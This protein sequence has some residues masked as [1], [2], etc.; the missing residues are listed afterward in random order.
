MFSSAINGEVSA[1]PGK[2]V[3]AGGQWRGAA[4]KPKHLLRHIRFGIKPR[5]QPSALSMK[6]ELMLVILP[7]SA[8]S[9]SSMVLQSVFISL[10]AI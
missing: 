6:F 3:S 5:D 8:I 9:I 1:E 4:E 10:A 7:V 2:A